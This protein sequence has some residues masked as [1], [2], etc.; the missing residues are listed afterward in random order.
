MKTV[1]AS[2]VRGRIESV[3][4][5]AKVK[6]YRAGENPGRWRG[7]LEHLLPAVSKVHKVKNHAALPYKDIPEFM[8]NLRRRGKSSTASALE[9]CI[10]TA[11]RSNETLEATTREIDLANGVWVIP[12]ERMKVGV[13][14]RVPLLGR[15][16]EIAKD[17]ANGGLLFPGEGADGL[18]E[19]NAML[20]L[21]MKMRV[22]ATVH[23]FRSTFDDWA[24]ETTDHASHIIDMALAHKIP[25]AT[26][27]A[28][29]RGDLF[30]KRHAL[31]A[32]WDAF[33]SSA[34]PGRV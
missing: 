5:W 31:M 10:L 9:F 33:C 18:L 17:A 27:A 22:A 19:K 25:D 29:R 15:A 30:V 7:H 3:L 24:S 21:L 13:E 20:E 26:K 32:D 23:G 4:D 16:F 12:A 34:R 8:A 14:H 28:Y 6:G 11:T 1:T 2:R